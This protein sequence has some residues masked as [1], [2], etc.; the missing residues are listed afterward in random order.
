VNDLQISAGGLGNR[1]RV[2]CVYCF[3]IHQVAAYAQS[4]RA[5]LDEAGCRLLRYTAC[6]DQFELRKGRVQRLQVAGAAYGRAG[7]NLHII[8]AGIPRGNGLGGR[9]RAGARNFIVL[10]G[11]GDYIQMK[12]GADDKLRTG[13]DRGLRLIG[14]GNGAGTKQELRS[15]F[16]F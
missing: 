4:A 12:A 14:G 3:K 7:K 16:F 11:G 15:V 1:F 2:A 8:R 10:L 9:Q 6:R 13:V 5:G